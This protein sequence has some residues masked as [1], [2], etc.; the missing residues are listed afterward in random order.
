M[1]PRDGVGYVKPNKITEI[2]R[3]DDYLFEIC[4][5]LTARDCASIAAT[6]SVFPNMIKSNSLIWRQLFLSKWR[7]HDHTVVESEMRDQYRKAFEYL[8]ILKQAALSGRWFEYNGFFKQA[9]CSYEFSIVVHCSQE[10]HIK[11][12]AVVEPPT[13]ELL[14]DSALLLDEQKDFC[15]RYTLENYLD[16]LPISHLPTYEDVYKIQTDTS[17]LPYPQ[18]FRDRHNLSAEFRHIFKEECKHLSQRF[19]FS[20]FKTYLPVGLPSDVSILRQTHLHSSCNPSSLRPEEILQFDSDNVSENYIAVEG[21]TTWSMTSSV[22]EERGVGK[23]A[24]EFVKGYYNKTTRVLYLAG[25]GRS[26][27]ALDADLGV[28]LYRLQISADGHS[29]K[30]IQ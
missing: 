17:A 2:L 5:F 19:Q 4:S 3:I 1:Q 21:F 12:T 24:Q 27:K 29:F 10:M 16:I 11:S 9:A 7:L 25:I 30:G 15:E 26:L 28:D 20:K 18:Y 6:N 8:E 22:R 14:H 13:I 23:K